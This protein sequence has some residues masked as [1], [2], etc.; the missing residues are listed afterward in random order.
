MTHDRYEPFRLSTVDA[1]G[2]A[3]IYCEESG[4]ADGTAALWLHGGP[5][6]SLGSGWYRTHFDRHDTDSSGS[7]NAAPAGAALRA[8]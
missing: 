1:D 3:G 2:G 5:G 8:V 6:G 4:N 7:T